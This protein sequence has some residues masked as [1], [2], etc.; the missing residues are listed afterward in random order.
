MVGEEIV[1]EL[2]MNDI[3]LNYNLREFLEQEARSCSLER[4]R[5]T[6]CVRV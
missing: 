2:E 3:E 4:K 6:S 5:C 1:K